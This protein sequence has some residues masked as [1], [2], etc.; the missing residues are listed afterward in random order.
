MAHCQLQLQ[1]AVVI[2]IDEETEQRDDDLLLIQWYAESG[3]QGGSKGRNKVRLEELKKTGFII[4]AFIFF[5]AFLAKWDNSIHVYFYKD[6]LV[7][8]CK[9]YKLC[10]KEKVKD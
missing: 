6:L 8:Y 3:G 7:V 10:W 1:K 5:D 2:E 4:I 9:L